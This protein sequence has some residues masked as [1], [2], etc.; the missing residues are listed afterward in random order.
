ML[1]FE[2]SEHRPRLAYVRDGYQSYRFSCAVAM[3][4][5]FLAI[6]DLVADDDVGAA[7]VAALDFEAIRSEIEVAEP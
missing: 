2:P 4:R 6:G 1:V 7:S 3:R 5:H